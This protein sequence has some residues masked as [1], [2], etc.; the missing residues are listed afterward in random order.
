M[1]TEHSIKQ[2]YNDETKQ[3]TKTSKW[4]NKY[5]NTWTY[6]KRKLQHMITMKHKQKQIKHNTSNEQI[7]YKWQQQTNET[8]TQPKEIPMTS[9]N[10]IT[11]NTTQTIQTMKQNKHM[12]NNTAQ[13][14]NI[15]YTMA[16]TNN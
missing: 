15:K 14:N 8:T 6:M 13:N 1:K 12:N 3:I 11:N 10:N 2:N 7:T 16:T 4:E 9:I 5:K